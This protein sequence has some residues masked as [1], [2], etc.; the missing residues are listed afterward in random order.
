MSLQVYTTQ[1]YACHAKAAEHK[2]LICT[3][4]ELTTVTTLCTS[5]SSWIL[6]DLCAAHMGLQSCSSVQWPSL[7][8]NSYLQTVW[9]YMR[10]QTCIKIFEWPKKKNSIGNPWWSWWVSLI[11]ENNWLI[12][13]LTFLGYLIT[14]MWR[15]VISETQSGRRLLTQFWEASYFAPDSFLLWPVNCWGWKLLKPRFT[16]WVCS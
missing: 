11:R 9:R 6:S 1:I 10:N 8:L 5:W 15:I 7:W 12:A 4:N 2:E 14:H 3:S 16:Q 13:Y